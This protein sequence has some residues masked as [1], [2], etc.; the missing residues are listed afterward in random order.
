MAPV[1]LAQANGPGSLGPRKWPRFAGPKQ[2]APVRWAQANGPGS[3]GRAAG[4]PAGGAPAE[5]NF[6]APERNFAKAPKIR[7]PLQFSP[8]SFLRPRVGRFFLSSTSWLETCRSCGG[9]NSEKKL[10]RAEFFENFKKNLGKF[11]AQQPGSD[12]ARSVGHG[13]P[14]PGNWW[15]CQMT[16]KW[17]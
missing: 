17:S 3:L 4:R 11:G 16:S 5:G 1:R 6:S 12:G 10:T 14:M 13:Q 9:K 2:M 15:F 7:Y 8:I